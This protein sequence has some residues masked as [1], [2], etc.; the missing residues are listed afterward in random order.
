VENSIID[1]LKKNVKL[2]LCRDCY[3]KYVS[4]VEPAI[5]MLLSQPLIDWRETEADITQ[6]VMK[7][8]GVFKD[9]KIQ[10]VYLSRQEKPEKWITNGVDIE[11][12]KKIECWSCEKKL[13][14]LHKYGILEDASFSL[15]DVARNLRNSIHDFTYIFSDQ[16]YFLFRE[17]SSIS[18][19]IWY[20]YNDKTLGRS[21][22][23]TRFKPS[24]E[25][26]AR[27]ILIRY[28]NWKKQTK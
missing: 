21:D 24:V 16:D 9:N 25:E 28:S 17:T 27:T 1:R 11:A 4:F 13:K 14:Y 3:N 2:N 7:H 6:M 5:V 15:I 10:G 23:W 26:E 19:K 20:L 8:E 22:F 18:K 12:Y